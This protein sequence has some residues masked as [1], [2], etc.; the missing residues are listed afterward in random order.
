M[1]IS[2]LLII[3]LL[4]SPAV[5]AAPMQGDI[6]ESNNDITV[7]HQNS[8]EWLT[9]KNYFSIEANKFN[10]K[11][12]GS[13]TAY[14]A[15]ETVKE[16]DTLIDN[17]PNGQECHMIFFHQRWRRVPDVLALDERLRNYG[18]CENVFNK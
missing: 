16:Y 18:G 5:F 6:K 12:Y 9:P 13:V 1:N 14:P 15:Y 11:N 2:T 4:A 3:G 7:W 8:G 17:L 10:G